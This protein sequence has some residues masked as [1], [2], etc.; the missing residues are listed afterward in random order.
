MEVLSV[1]SSK[2]LRLSRTHTHTLAEMKG[3][4]R[5]NTNNVYHTHNPVIIWLSILLRKRKKIRNASD[6]GMKIKTVKIISKSLD[7]IYH[8]TLKEKTK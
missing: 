3:K 1:I 4:R 5:E 6:R 8:P 2:S 7:S